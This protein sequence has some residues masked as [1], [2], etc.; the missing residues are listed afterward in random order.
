M[1][2]KNLLQSVVLLLSLIAVFSVNAEV[3]G[4]GEYNGYFNVT[5]WGYKV[6]HLGPYYLFVSDAA[7]KSLK[8]YLGKPLKIKVKKLS[9]PFNP[10]AGLIEEI[11]SISEEGT[12]RGLIL[13]ASLKSNKVVQGQGIQLHLSLFNNSKEPITIRPN[14]LAI[15]LITDSPFSNK[16]I[17]YKDPD[18][19]GY[20]KYS[21]F[22]GAF[23]KKNKQKRI[24]CRQIIL[25]WKR[26]YL[27]N[28]GQNIH[29]ENK[30][31]GFLGAIVIEPQGKFEA[32]YATGKELLPDDYEVFFYLR[33]GNL[34]AIPGPMSDCL[35]FDVIKSKQNAKLQHTSGNTNHQK[36]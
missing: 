2:I 18:N 14:T 13:S 32:E 36:E 7:A 8:N 16:S 15:V 22:Y 29:I 11:A 21:Y 12:A 28:Q 27:V 1:N 3:I 9:Q 35:S 26:E 24:A 23:E 31:R 34:S 4:P 30:R 10:G 19:Y 33:T 25:P 5:R 20:W 6:F 17:G